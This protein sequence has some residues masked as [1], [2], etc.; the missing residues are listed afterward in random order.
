MKLSAEQL[1]HRLLRSSAHSSADKA[2]LYGLAAAGY[3]GVAIDEILRD[4]R[5]DRA[6]F[7]TNIER[8]DPSPSPKE[9]QHENHM[10]IPT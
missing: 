3:A 9:E 8:E 1:L 4:D 6:C 10:E 2:R 7:P 5:I